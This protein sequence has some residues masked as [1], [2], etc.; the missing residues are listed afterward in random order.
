MEEKMINPIISDVMAKYISHI[1]KVLP[2]D[3]VKSLEMLRDKETNAAALGFYETMFRNMELAREQGRPLCQDTG[4][5]QFKIKCGTE[6]SALRELEGSLVQSVE[7]AT[8]EAPLRPNCIETFEE[9]NPG[10]N[11][12]TG[13]PAIWWELEPGRDDCE[14]CVYLAGGGCS[15]PGR[16][17]VFTPGAGYDAII[18]FVMDRVTEMGLNACPPLLIGV[19]I[20]NS[21]ETA[22]MNSKVALMRGVDSEN[23]NEKAAKLEKLLEEGL[24]EIG[25]G[26]QGFGGNSSVMGVNVVNSV[27]HP[28]TFAAAVSFG[29]WCHRRGVIVFDKDLN[30][31]TRTHPHFEIL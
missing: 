15:L 14:I 9:K 19:G 22:A 10:T 6:F 25:I 4:I 21:I 11:V 1:S 13:A 28:A 12:G 20:G 17:E 29:C 18:P 3:V 23:S 7:K 26:P 30:Y 5:V 8:E 16:A 2:D 24:N 31:S 27:R